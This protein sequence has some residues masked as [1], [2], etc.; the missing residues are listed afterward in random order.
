MSEEI[1]EVL[2]L[3][4]RRKKANSARA[5]QKKLSRARELAKRHLAGEDIIRK[6]AYRAARKSVRRRFASKRGEEYDN[7]TS[8]EKIAVDKL[9]AK[10]QKLIN[11]LAMR[12]IPTIRRN[13]AKRL[14]SFMKG[15]PLQD[16]H[17]KVNESFDEMETTFNK[18]G[19]KNIRHSNSTYHGAYELRTTSKHTHRL[20]GELTKA[21]WKKH[22]FRA[23]HVGYDAHGNTYWA[24]VHKFSH[25]EHGT[26]KIRGTSTQLPKGTLQRKYEYSN[27]VI[28]RPKKKIDESFEARFSTFLTE[29][30]ECKKKEKKA[31]GKAK[32][33]IVFFGKFDEN[34][35]AYRAIHKKA[36]KFGIDVNILGEVYDRG[37]REWSEDSNL[38]PEQTAFARVN[39][40][41]NGGAALQEDEDLLGRELNEEYKKGQRVYI[42]NKVKHNTPLS[43]TVHSV[44]DDHV[45][46]NAYN[47]GSNKYKAHKNDVSLNK[48]DSWIHRSKVDESV[49]EGYEED[50]ANFDKNVD[51]IQKEHNKKSDYHYNKA[52]E[53]DEASTLNGTF[54]DLHHLNK[55]R[56][57]RKACAAHSDAAG[58][59][60]MR[61]HSA[62]YKSKEANKLS[63]ALNEDVDLN[64]VSNKTL[65]SYIKKTK[66]DNDRYEKSLYDSKTRRGLFKK[67]GEYE[68]V[69]RR[70]IGTVMAKRKLENRIVAHRA[71]EIHDHLISSGYKKEPS[72][73]KNHEKYSKESD[74]AKHHVI[75]K[76]GYH[77]YDRKVYHKIIS[78]K[79]GHNLWAGGPAVAPE[80]LHDAFHN[81]AKTSGKKII[82]SI[83]SADEK[84]K[85]DIHEENLDELSKKILMN[86]ANKAGDPVR[87][88]NRK[89]GF[90]AALVKLGYGN[91]RAKIYAKEE[92]ENLNELVQPIPTSTKHELLDKHIKKYS[93][94]GWKYHGVD[95]R[96]GHVFKKRSYMPVAI[97]SKEDGGVVHIVNNGTRSREYDKN[98]KIIQKKYGGFNEDVVLNEDLKTEKDKT[99][100]GVHHVYWKGKKLNIRIVNTRAGVVGGTGRGSN[101][102]HYAIYYPSKN[103]YHHVGT[104]EQTKRLI[105]SNLQQQEGVKESVDEGYTI[106]S[107]GHEKVHLI[108]DG[109]VVGKF[110]NPHDAKMHI[111]KLKETPLDEISK[112]TLTNYF[113]KAQDQDRK[114]FIQGKPPIRKAGVLKAK[115]K[116]ENMK[117]DHP[118]CGTPECCGQCNEEGNSQNDPS[119]RLAGTDSLVAA[120]KKDTPGQDTNDAFSKTFNET[121]RTA[122]K[123]AVIIPAHYDEYGNLIPAKSVNRRE[124]KTIVHGGDNPNDGK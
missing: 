13:E 21:G 82:S 107:V 81:T 96:G 120:F 119:K 9:I 88:L 22:S 12:L 64:E 50:L 27:T 123:Q 38:S 62:F 35:P 98:D 59:I 111:S 92:A 74:H 100:T 110:T 61:H 10:K 40:F 69:E 20:P 15:A 113:H 25:P 37:L 94:A 54:K 103:K 1:E 41:I 83:S 19:Y 47:G 17:T 104:M 26:I 106:R 46:I 63:D 56:A 71:K 101:K 97:H 34:N 77:D 48:E 124:N 89:R 109:K 24:G 95:K 115:N 66:P 117:E 116:I 42:K 79:Y 68:R 6:R 58:A 75:I 87:K 112:E 118:N 32:N 67:D 93:D 7:L 70:A 99:L 90:D 44:T 2:D 80:T 91:G 55:A 30:E 14:Q 121:V 85:N 43:G 11:R 73:V 52:K 18:H 23:E 86:Y 122:V 51:K 33:K 78:K 57:H 4:Q 84:H 36:E 114:R 76:H 53:H 102:T 31:K 72:E 108:K 49:Y 65:K 5:N 3:E 29:A 16:M 8:S 45:I 28:Y 105:H 39:S 60:V